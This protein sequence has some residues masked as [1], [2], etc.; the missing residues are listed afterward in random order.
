VEDRLQHVVGLHGEI[1]RYLDVL[2]A[3]AVGAVA[4]TV[5][6]EDLRHDF[7]RGLL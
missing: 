5:G 6:I 4:P 7:A 2:A 1:G 3:G